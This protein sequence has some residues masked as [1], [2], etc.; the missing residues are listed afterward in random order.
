MCLFLFLFGWMNLRLSVERNKAL[1]GFT[2]I[3]NY[4]AST[5]RDEQ[6]PLGY[7]TVLQ[8]RVE[9]IQG[10]YNTLLFLSAHQNVWVFVEDRQV[11]RLQAKE[12]LFLPKSPGLV[13][14]EVVFRE[15]DNGRLVRIE[16]QPIYEGPEQMPVLTLGSGYEIV[17]AILYSNLPILVLCILII[18]IGVLQIFVALASEKRQGSHAGATIL[19]SCFVIVIGM[20]KILDSSFMG[21]FEKWIP[22]FSVLSLFVLMFLPIM[23]SIILRDILEDDK[24]ELWAVADGVTLLGILI[25]IGLQ[26]LGFADFRESLWI[27]QIC[28]AV[29]FAWAF[30]RIFQIVKGNGWTKNA[31]MTLVCALFGVFWV[32]V[33]VFTYYVTSGV[34]SFPFGM[35]LFLIFLLIMLYQR[36]RISKQRMEVGM[37]ARQYKK[38]AYHDALTGF[39]NRAAYVDFIAGEDF[40]LNNS[41]LVTFDLNN[42]KKCNDEFGHDKG[43]VYIKESAKIIQDCFG[44]RGRCYRLGGDEFGA[45]LPNGTLEGCA[46]RVI[47]MRELVDRFNAASR[48]FRMGIACGYAV[49]D[50]L[51]DEDVHATIRRADKMM[52][53]EKFQMKQ[54]VKA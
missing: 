5:E 47:R 15:E 13:Y 18:F 1:M 7:K 3:T 42:L 36:M 12:G 4:A 33:D 16:L 52:Y 45:I 34:T 35:L 54:Q 11:Y 10:D 24:K 29:T 19:H 32:F 44:E 23:I 41:V 22:A 25:M 28:L 6:A 43:D 40:T 26:C 14:N 9:N 46:E 2:T 38:L 53:E 30:L 21:L 51:E 31:K 8:F 17:K 20:W 39:F 27:A 49:F 37:Q 50:P 48:D